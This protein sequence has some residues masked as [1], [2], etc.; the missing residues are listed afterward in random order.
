[1]ATL[2]AGGKPA[3][4]EPDVDAIVARLEAEAEDGDVIVVFSNGGFGGIHDRLL[5][6]L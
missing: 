4:Y 3:Y 1:M 5:S 2:R 6:E